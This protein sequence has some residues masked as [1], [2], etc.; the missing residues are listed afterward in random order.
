VCL[1]PEQAGLRPELLPLAPCAFLF[2]FWYPKA[3]RYR[4]RR[5]DYSGRMF[6]SLVLQGELRDCVNLSGFEVGIR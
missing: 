3:A 5:C 6:L 1:E 2:L 4:S